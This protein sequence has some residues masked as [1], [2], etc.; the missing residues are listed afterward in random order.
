M[1]R[2]ASQEFAI[3]DAVVT[4]LGTD[5]EGNGVIDFTTEGVT[6]WFAMPGDRGNVMGYCGFQVFD[7]ALDGS[8]ASVMVARIAR[9]SP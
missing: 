9:H 6:R 3:C 1:A 2:G 7:V 5:V 4:Y 8:R